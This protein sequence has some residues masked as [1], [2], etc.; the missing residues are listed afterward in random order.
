MSGSPICVSHHHEQ[1]AGADEHTAQRRLGGDLFME[2]Q[3]RQHQR[4]DHAEL[5]DGDHLAGGAQLQ[6][7]VT[8]ERPSACTGCGFENSCAIRGCAVLRSVSRVVAVVGMI[9]ER[10]ICVRE[11]L[12]ECRLPL[13]WCAY[14]ALIL[15]VVIFAAYGDGY[16]KVDLIYAGF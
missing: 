4:D 3:R 10:G 1:R 15:A 8:E 9:K 16:Q 13:R 2:Q 5:V 12:S 7:L 14:Y 11:R 6:R